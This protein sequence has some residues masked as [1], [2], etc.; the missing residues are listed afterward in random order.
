MCRQWQWPGWLA[1]TSPEHSPSR[2]LHL[3]V[4]ARLHAWAGRA[5]ACKGTEEQVWHYDSCMC[6][7][8]T[9]VAKVSFNAVQA[10]ER[11]AVP[12]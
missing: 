4:C 8:A 12:A 3:L 5:R 2:F 9:A 10:R 7:E 6:S 11:W 1:W